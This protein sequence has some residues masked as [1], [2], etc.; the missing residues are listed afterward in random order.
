MTVRVGSEF[1][2][3]LDYN[4]STGASWESVGGDGSVRLVKSEVL[5]ATGSVGSSAQ[6]RFRFVGDKPGTYELQFVLKRPWETIIRKT[7]QRC[8]QVEADG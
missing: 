4:P 7:E 1:E 6:M 3:A 8:V 5:P 2:I